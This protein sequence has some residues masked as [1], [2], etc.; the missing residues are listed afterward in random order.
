MLT[1]LVPAP[2]KVRRTQE[3]GYDIELP[4]VETHIITE[5]VTIMLEHSYGQF[6]SWEIISEYVARK[7]CDKFFFQYKGSGIPPAIIWFFEGQNI[8]VGERVDLALEYNGS[9]YG[10]CIQKTDDGTDQTMI[11]WDDSLAEEFE[12]YANDGK[13]HVMEFQ[14]VGDKRYM[15]EFYEADDTQRVWLITWNKNY[16]DWENFEEICENTKA[17]QTFIISWACTNNNPR[18]DEEVFLLK[19]GDQP[20]GIIG[21]GK[22]K[23]TSYEKEHYVPAKAAEGKRIKAI[24]R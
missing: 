20:R 13:R 15:I 6:D 21:H 24:D 22:V 11:F 2:I 7:N 5:R 17:G 19:L 14:K 9:E 10:G 23:R 12:L 16:W 8:G 3:L 1:T 18:I 4:Y